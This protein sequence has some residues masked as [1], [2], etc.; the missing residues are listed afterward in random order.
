MKAAMYY[1]PGD[2]R[3]EDVPEPD[4]GPGEVKVRPLWNGL[5][6][7]DLHQFFDGPMS[8]VV[9]CIIGHEFSAEVVE[10]GRDVTRVSV[11]DLVAVD[12]MWAC[13]TCKHCSEGDRNL[14][15]DMICH[16]LGASGG[17]ISECDRRAGGHAAP[18]PRGRRRRSRPRWSSR[19]RSRTTA[20]CQ[21]RP[22]PGTTAVVLGGGPI[23]IG[24]LPGA[25]CAGRRRRH[26]V[27]AR[28]RAPRRAGLR[29]VPSRCST[30]PRP[31]SRPR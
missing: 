25:A 7:T 5:C 29:S 1:G 21:G 2:I 22:R 9:P 18:R 27:G 8:L 11:G 10:V 6:G 4:P 28:G 16:G 24:A 19:C 31:T 26:R 14:C 15:F 3:M 17:G 30:P 23:G 20:C 13:G 12:P